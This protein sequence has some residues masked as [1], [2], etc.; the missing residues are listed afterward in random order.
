MTSHPQPETIAAIQ[1]LYGRQSHLIDSGAAREWAETFTPDG[2]FDSPSYPN[3]VVGT[4]AL[5]QFARDF[6]ASAFAKAE[7]HR[8]VITNLHIERVDARTL[9]VAAYLQIIATKVAGPSALL[10]FTTLS[11]TVRHTPDGW[12]VARRTVARDDAPLPQ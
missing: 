5:T 1:Q 10:R 2:V 3:P 7:R 6:A 11:D 12:R 9:T 4:E 8:H